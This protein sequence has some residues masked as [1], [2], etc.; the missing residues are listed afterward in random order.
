MN[1]ITIMYLVTVLALILSACG[2]SN[3][4]Q[5]ASSAQSGSTSATLPMATQLLI[6]TFKLEGTDLAVTEN[7]PPTSCR[8]GR[9][10]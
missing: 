6:G 4:T 2:A 1:K 8:S 5:A 7:R 9:S 10:T 3:S